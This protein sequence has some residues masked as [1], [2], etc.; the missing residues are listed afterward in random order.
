LNP[1]TDVSLCLFY[2][3][4]D[5][6]SLFSKLP[7]AFITTLLVP[8]DLENAKATISP[9][10]EGYGRLVSIDKNELIGSLSSSSII[11]G[12]VGILSAMLV[13]IVAVFLIRFLLKANL[14]KEYR[15]IGIYKSQG[16]S[17]LSIR[18][19]YF[20]CYVFVGGIS[21]ILGVLASLPMSYSLSDLVT[22]YMTNYSDDSA[23]AFGMMVSFSSLLL[24]L[25]ISVY[26]ATR[27][28][29][30]ITPV[31]ALRM[32][33]TSSKAKFKRSIVRNAY[34][35]LS[36]AINDIGKHK[37]YSAMII[38]VLCLSFY[39]A[40]FSLSMKTTVDN[41]A[42]NSDVWF[43]LPRADLYVTGRIDDSLLYNLESNPAIKKVIVSEELFTTA[44]KLDEI[45][46]FNREITIFS[47]SDFSDIPY[48][49]GRAPTGVNETAV[50]N[51]LLGELGLKA[52]DYISV[53]LGNEKG[54]FLI[55][56]V[57]SGLINSG[58]FMHFPAAS[59][60]SFGVEFIP[61][62]LMVML[63]DG[64]SS[65]HMI[66]YIHQEFKGVQAAKILDMAADA[67]KGVQE[68]ISPVMLALIVTFAIFS[69][70]C[71]TNL[72]IQNHA[73]NRRQYGVMKSMGFSTRYIATRSILRIFLLSVIA[74]VFSMALHLAFSKGLFAGFVLVDVLLLVIPEVL[75]LLF[76]LLMLIMTLTLIFCLPIRKITPQELIEE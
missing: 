28:I 43:S 36:M 31:A 17:S 5:D 19:F 35:P 49:Q 27:P 54:T 75:I 68:M 9:L 29:K 76:C 20:K 40:M 32:G 16:F 15:S 21:I 34:S 10:T 71:I 65:E 3:A 11:L 55:A 13:F 8:D 72:I 6:F 62:V 4:A 48:T 61:G 14:V 38:T 70:L 58:Y 41:V 46:N 47:F 69:V 73:D 18:G 2:V 45:Y 7:S 53:T 25:I 37:G 30:K 42:E 57:F 63:N 44:V 23:Y 1:S 24:I 33:V 66:D 60:P 56:G 59:L 67:A 22:R 64:E 50:S 26:A 52:G 51:I 74:A 39:L 12:G